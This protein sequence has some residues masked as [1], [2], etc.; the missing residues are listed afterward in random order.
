MTDSTRHEHLMINTAARSTAVAEGSMTDSTRQEHP[1]TS[2]AAGRMT[3][4]PE[5]VLNDL[6]TAAL[7][8]KDAGS[9]SRAPRKVTTRND[10]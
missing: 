7:D 1:M 2:T 4:D 6:G 3:D 5:G 8:P 9:S 10:R